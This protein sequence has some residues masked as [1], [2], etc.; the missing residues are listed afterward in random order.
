[1]QQ[2]FKKLIKDENGQ[3]QVE[4]GNIIALVSIAVIAT[5]T[6]L[7]QSLFKGGF[8]NGEENTDPLPGGDDVVDPGGNNNGDTMSRFET[9]LKRYFPRLWRWIFG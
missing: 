6:I 7:G 8:L 3:S 5:L 9:F 1:M 2:L 4:Y